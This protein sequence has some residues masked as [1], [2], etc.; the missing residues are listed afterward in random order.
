MRARR[1]AGPG[2]PELVCDAFGRPVLFPLDATFEDVYRAGGPGKYKLI[3]VDA[4]GFMLEDGPFCMTGMMQPQPLRNAG[5]DGELD[6]SIAGAHGSSFQ[7]RDFRDELLLHLITKQTQMAEAVIRGVPAWMQAS[8][9]LVAAA[10]NAKLT[11]RQPV[12][13]PPPAEEPEAAP[14]PEPPPSRMPAW[15]KEALE[16]AFKAIAA[17]LGEKVAGKLSGM[18]LEALFDWSK[19]TPKP[20]APDSAPSPTAPAAATPPAPSAPAMDPRWFYAA[21]GGMPTDAAWFTPAATVPTPST[22]WAATAPVEHVPMDPVWFTPTASGAIPP[23]PTWRGPVPSSVPQAARFA[24]PPTGAPTD[25]AWY[26][27]AAGDGTPSTASTSAPMTSAAPLDPAWYSAIAPQLA[28]PSA[29]IMAAP[30]ASVATADAAPASET[31]ATAPASSEATMPERM[32]DLSDGITRTDRP[33]TL[34]S[35]S[36]SSAPAIA[37]PSTVAPAALELTVPAPVAPP[38]P[39]RPSGPGSSSSMPGAPPVAPN[40]DAPMSLVTAATARGTPP[41]EAHAP[42]LR[43]AGA[44]RAAPASTALARRGAMFSPPLPPTP[45]IGSAPAMPSPPTRRRTTTADSIALPSYILEIYSALTPQE[46]ERTQQLVAMLTQEE[47]VQWLIELGALTLP[48]AIA[49]VRALIRPAT[50]AAR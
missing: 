26:A 8:A 15:F 18:P 35:P 41:A 28:A 19:A 50:P 14:E 23:H 39:S 43:S 21:S 9:E 22:A 46:Q 11:T 17:Q 29:P 25:I 7:P 44:A 16:L 38:H 1:I 42:Q 10:D 47:R 49:R 20:P 6:T 45:N 2:R 4:S 34:A 31:A 32:P 30:L 40:A 37:E 36:V 33:N 13:V 3:F 24:A 12:L 48:D 5:A 27:A